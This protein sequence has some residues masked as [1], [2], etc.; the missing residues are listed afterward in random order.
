MQCLVGGLQW[1]LCLHVCIYI[2]VTMGPYLLFSSLIY[3][4]LISN[5]WQQQ[6]CSVNQ[7]LLNKAC[8]CFVTFQYFHGLFVPISMIKTSWKCSLH[9]FTIQY[10]FIQVCLYGCNYIMQL[11]IVIVGN[12]FFFFFKS[13]FCIRVF[14]L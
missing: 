4:L 6:S 11:H 7:I 13:C 5:F 9:S 1:N 12:F 2:K 8:I 10:L 14:F 3:N